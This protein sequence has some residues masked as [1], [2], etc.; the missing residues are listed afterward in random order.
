MAD[1]ADDEPA[2]APPAAFPDQ[3]AK[4]DTGSL[5]EQV[6][7]LAED[8]RTA[9]E[10]E[11]AWQTARAGYAARKVSA[12]AAWGGLALV[13]GFIA[14]LAVAF[15]AILTLAP[16]IGPGLATAAVT[17]VLLVGALVAA[18]LARSGI[19]KLR[20]DLA[21]KPPEA[22]PKPPGASQ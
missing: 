7:D 12:I 8:A 22:S 18:M 17:A 9:L 11:L 1:P 14:V 10:A 20:G 6:K 4:D 5:V 15:G 13:C 3:E 2:G 19:R 16:V 21:A